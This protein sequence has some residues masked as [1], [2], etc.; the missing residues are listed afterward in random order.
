MNNKKTSTKVFACKPNGKMYDVI[1]G[2]SIPKQ[3]KKLN[4]KIKNKIKSNGNNI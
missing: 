3:I 4:Y 2:V 1:D